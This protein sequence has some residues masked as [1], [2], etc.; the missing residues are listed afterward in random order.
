MLMPQI[1]FGHCLNRLDLPVISDTYKDLLKMSG[2]S[3]FCISIGD[4]LTSISFPFVK[5]S[6]KKCKLWG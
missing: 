1:L 6:L 3:M 2:A 5:K 4:K